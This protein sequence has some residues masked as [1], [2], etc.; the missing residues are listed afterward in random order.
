MCVVTFLKTKKGVFLTSNRDEKNTRKALYPKTYLHDNL[1]LCYPKDLEKGGT[2]F[3][4]D[5]HQ[6]RATCLLNAKGVQPS[7]TNQLS[8]GEIP[9]RYLTNEKSILSKPILIKMAPFT[10][11]C[12]QYDNDFLVKE[13]AWNGKQMDVK[14]LD[15]NVPHI[16]CS[17]TLYG[18]TEKDRLTKTFMKKSH[19]LMTLEDIVSFHKSVAQP[20]KANV[21][22]KQDEDLQTV[23]ITSI[24]ATQNGETSYYTDL[25]DGATHV[26]TKVY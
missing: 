8:R 24:K 4:L 1:Q 26:L 18:K 7:A 3:A 16:W 13:Y 9:I 25:L 2:W 20:P 12:M 10:L 15:E 19:N 5:T 17:N 23:S 14:I 11:I 21:F 22:L 6:K